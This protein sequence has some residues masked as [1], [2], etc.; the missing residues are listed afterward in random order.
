MPNEYSTKQHDEVEADSKA[1][2]EAWLKNNESGAT[3][4]TFR[5]ESGFM[6][7]GDDEQYPDVFGHTLSDVIIGDY[8]T[9]A[10][11]RHYFLF[12]VSTDEMYTRDLHQKACNMVNELYFKG[13]GFSE[14]DSRLDENPGVEIP[15][16][17]T[18]LFDADEDGKLEQSVAREHFSYLPYDLKETELEGY[19]LNGLSNGDVWAT[20]LE[21]HVSK[22]LLIDDIKLGIIRDYPSF[23]SISID[24]S[25]TDYYITVE[26]G[27]VKGKK[28]EII[29]IEA[30][31]PIVSSSTGSSTP[32][33]SNDVIRRIYEYD[34][35]TLQYLRDF[36]PDLR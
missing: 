23:Y 18:Y 16:D 6:N 28:K 14:E 20:H 34:L 36:D 29:S 7:N 22:D 13:L 32:T 25:E 31:T 5:I 27:D 12:N 2:V 26:K 4:G 3:L 33:S 10:G 15:V 30:M 9:S 19:V 1:K 8:T 24:S 35:E 17:F 11:E 21:Y